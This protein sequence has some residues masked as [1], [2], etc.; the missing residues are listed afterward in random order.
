MANPKQISVMRAA[1]GCTMRI[2]ERA[3]RE[4]A[5]SEKSVFGWSWNNDSVEN[6]Q[7]ELLH[8]YI[9]QHTSVVPYHGALAATVIWTITQHTKVDV[10]VG[11]KRDSRNNRCREGR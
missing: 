9:E 4:A 5:G 10:T 11:R 1:M 8:T 3:W 2:E 7:L 6:G